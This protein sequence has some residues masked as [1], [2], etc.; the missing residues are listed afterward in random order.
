VAEIVNKY[1]REK[2]DPQ[3]R[4]KFIR[5]KTVIVPLDDETGEAAGRISAERRTSVSG[6]G[7]VDSCVLAVARSREAKVVTGD[8]HFSGLEEALI[9]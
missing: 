2:I 3:D 6:W 7:L 1:V 9:I 4:L 8:N 5:T